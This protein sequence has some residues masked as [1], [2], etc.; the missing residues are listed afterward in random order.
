MGPG[1][2][3]SQ[4]LAKFGIDEHCNYLQMQIDACVSYLTCCFLDIYEI[5]E[6]LV[7]NQI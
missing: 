7:P 5:R 6:I 4:N 2:P 3:S 1:M